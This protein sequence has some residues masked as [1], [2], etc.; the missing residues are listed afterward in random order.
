[1]KVVEPKFKIIYII[2][3]GRNG[4]TLVDIVLGNSR[5]IQSTGELF[6]TIGAWKINKVCS[7]NKDVNDCQFWSKVKKLFESTSK[8][9]DLNNILS[10]QKCFERSMFS[11]V[12]LFFNR[13]FHTKKYQ[14]YEKYLREFYTTIASVSGKPALVDSSK[15]PFRGYALL[16]SFQDNIYFIHLIRDGR[17]QM[18]SWIKAGIIPPFNIAVRKNREGN[19]SEE[20]K[21]HFWWTPF[22]YAFSWILYNMISYLVVLKAGSNKSIHI[23]Y[24]DFVKN[25]SFYIKKIGA[26]IDEDLHELCHFVD[27]KR[28]LAINHIL[29]G[30][31]HRHL[32]QI[33]IRPPDDEWKVLL[34]M[35]D[36]YIFW[37]IAGWLAKIYGYAFKN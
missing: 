8:D 12:N 34:P 11:P 36:R 24:E 29:A 27:K 4:S 2:G 30:S 6:N 18:W 14:Q 32:K 7:C 16:N 3:T 19:R 22:L 5:K 35:K 17:G 13:L 15:N 33:T 28:P 25:P 20:E 37:L 10:L 9:L 1:M 26:L 23:L 31:R 21:Q